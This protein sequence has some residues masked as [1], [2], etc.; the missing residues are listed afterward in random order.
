VR[1]PTG[2]AIRP[3]LDVDAG[4]IAALSSQLGYPSTREEILT[5]MSTLAAGGHTLILVAEDEGAVAG[6]IAV[7]D[8][9]SLETG[10]FAEIAGLVV[11]QASRGR[12]I[13]EALVVAAESWARERG[14][15]R[16]RVRS[17]VIRERA[18][19]FYERLGYTTTKRQA[20]FD[21]SL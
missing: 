8:D 6:W 4:A 17:N 14:H 7:R 21:K 15:G 2:L 5:R 3:A 1:S 18:H 11:D 10:P 12:R 19:R 9:V 16:M 13:G 20:V